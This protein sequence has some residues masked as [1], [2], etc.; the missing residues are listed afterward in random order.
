[1]RL[2]K[3]DLEKILFLDI[4]TVPAVYNFGD[5]DEK[6]ADLYLSKNKYI[7]ER[8]GLTNEEVYEKAGVF[9]L[10]HSVERIHKEAGSYP[11][12]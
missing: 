9:A 6:T 12:A 10:L 5:L 8:D 11:N 1:M 2:Q 7:Q 4:E 3:I